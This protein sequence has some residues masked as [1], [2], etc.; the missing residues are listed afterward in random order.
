MLWVGGSIII[1]GLEGFGLAEIAHF[2]EDMSARVREF[3]TVASGFLGWATEALL[4][5]IFGLAI[6]LV[7]L[8]VMMAGTKLT[9]GLRKG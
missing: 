5:G 7:V 6:G 8:V 4:S 1:H 2:V 3:T 9:A